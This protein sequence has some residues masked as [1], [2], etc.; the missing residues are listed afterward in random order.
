L[1]DHTLLI[2]LKEIESIIVTMPSHKKTEQNKWMQETKNAINER[3]EQ[4]Q[5]RIQERKIRELT[6]QVR[7]LQTRL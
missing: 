6:K 3:L 7:V 4:V 1:L 5:E 2:S